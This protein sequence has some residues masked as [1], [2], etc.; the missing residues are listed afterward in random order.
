MLPHELAR[1]SRTPGRRSRRRARRSARRRGRPAAGERARRRARRAAARR[2][3]ARPRGATR[4]VCE[5]DPLEQ[6]VGAAQPL[7]RRGRRAGRAAA[8]RARAR[9]ARER[10][11]GRSAGP[12]SRGVSS[13]T[14]TGARAGSLPRS[15]PSTRTTPADGRS[16]PARIRSSVDLPEP[17]G[18][19]TVSTSPSA[20]VSE[21][22]CSA[23]A[24]PSGV[25][26]T[27]KTSLNSIAFMQPPRRRG[28]ASAPRVVVARAT[29]SAASAT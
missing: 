29:S 20:T 2:P 9:S 24:S 17:L 7:A 27:R 23:A 3:R 25:E 19:S 13:G 14:S 18:P 16:R 8:R 1:A 22:P 12:R 28:P 4:F 26:W 15:S 5:A 6:L 11:R 10:A 21:R